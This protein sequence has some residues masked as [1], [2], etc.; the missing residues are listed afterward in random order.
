M[1]AADDLFFNILFCFSFFGC[2]WSHFDRFPVELWLAFRGFFPE[3]S[4]IWLVDFKEI[5]SADPVWVHLGSILSF[6]SSVNFH[7]SFVIVL[8][9][10]SQIQTKHPKKKWSAFSI[11]AH[12]PGRNIDE[13]NQKELIKSKFHYI[14]GPCSKQTRPKWS[15]I[16]LETNRNRPNSPNEPKT[17]FNASSRIQQIKSKCNHESIKSP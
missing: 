8:I 4:P 17:P 7:I 2:F 12:L 5:Q 9:N 13:L 6:G 11:L 16:W 1:H 3:F 10:P 15:R 14:F